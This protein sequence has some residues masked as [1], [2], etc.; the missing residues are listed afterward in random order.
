MENEIFDIIIIGAGPAGLTAGLYASRRTLKTLILTKDLGGQAAITYDVENY[1]GV[2]VI[3]GPALMEKFKEQAQNFGAGIKF[4]EVRA[5]NQK[6]GLFIIK[7]A[8]EEFQAKS[9]ILAFGLLPRDLDIP[10]EQKFKGRGVSYC[11]VCDGPLYKNKIA[12]VVGGGNAALDAAEYLAKLAA[13][14]YLIHR[15][16]QFR[17][18]E[19]IVERLKKDPKVEMV[20]S[21]QIVEIKGGNFVE[22]VVLKEN[23]G[24]KTREIKVSG[25]FVEIGYVAKTEL[26]KNLVK[27]NEKGE[28]ITDKNTST[29]CPGIFACGDVT[30]CGYKQ[31]VISAGEGA[32]AALQA[33]KYLC[34]RGGEKILPDWERK[35]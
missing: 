4:G 22:A 35:W 7:T 6:D 20:L 30:D 29:S 8:S 11:A 24:D 10:G 5:I 26:V 2:Q 19:V 25:V 12:A 32:K 27:L 13:K 23:G 34:L 28:I 16:D 15:R 18:E 14:V 33:Y 9:L 3:D 31:I 1:P 21:S 17:G